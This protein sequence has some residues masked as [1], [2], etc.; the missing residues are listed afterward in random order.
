MKYPS[1]QKMVILLAL[2][3]VT[4]SLLSFT[5]K[6]V[7]K[8][9]VRKKMAGARKWAGF[10]NLAGIRTIVIDPGHGGFDD[11]CKGLFSKEKDVALA[12]SL[13]LGPAIQEAFPGIKIIYT[14][15]TDI[16][17]GNAT[18]VHSGL[19]YRADL[20]NRSRGDLFLCIHCDSDGHTPG[21]Y[22]AKRVIGYKMA[23]KGRRRRKRPIYEE[24]IGHHTRAGTS[25]FVWKSQWDSYK[26]SV[27]QQQD[28]SGE[29]MGDSADA[30]VDISSP[31]AKMRAQLYEKKY[32]ANS[33]LFATLI[34][35]AFIK[36]GR[37]SDGVQQRPVGIW[38]L[39]ATGMPSV[40]VE[41]GF[42]TN[43]DEEEYL[44]S[45]DGQNEVVNNLVDALKTYAG[46]HDGASSGARSRPLGGSR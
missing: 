14:R 30:V 20:A 35:D 22:K 16:M 32:F 17:P 41:T 36:A 1:I 45:D 12:I 15:T 11:G 29:D 3:A 5:G 43:K 10:P 39:E 9:S 4:G 44:N 46:S 38:V 8:R 18:D 24:Y 27:I 26:G 28:Q 34:N 25:T 21:D 23:G 2:T 31:E 37:H 13:R 19:V 6:P 40:L 33:A 42:L 7:R